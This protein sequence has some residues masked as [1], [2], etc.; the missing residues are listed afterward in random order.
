M[1]HHNNNKIIIGDYQYDPRPIGYGSFSIVYKGYSIR[2]PDQCCAIKKITR[3]VD[4]KSFQNEVDVMRQLNHP[5]ILKLYDVYQE[6]DEF[7]LVLEFCRDGDLS[8]YIDRRQTTHDVLYMR[9]ILE[10]L[11]YLHSKQ[12]LHRDLK[13][14]NVLL[15]HHVI[16]ISDF[17]FSK[18]IASNELI[19][20]YCGSPMYMSPE[21]IKTHQYNLKSDI[22]SLGVILYELFAKRHPYPVGNKKELQMICLH[23]RIRVDMSVFINPMLI[24]YL[25]LL[26]QSDPSRRSEWPEVFRVGKKVCGEKEVATVRP[27][28][29]PIPI[30]IPQSKSASLPNKTHSILPPRAPSHSFTLS[31][32]HKSSSSDHY[33]P[34]PDSSYSSS[35]LGL[36]KSLNPHYLHDLIKSQEDR[37]TTHTKPILGHS[38]TFRPSHSFS[39]LLDKTI[40]SIWK[41]SDK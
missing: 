8:K 24:E 39:S 7:Y 16:K 40:K 10:G 19:S 35:P 23:D 4:T 11:E 26:L 1:A 21:M 2:D 22:W 27:R 41:S 30:P 34:S 32:I 3:L 6:Q 13:P 17:G 25:H 5:N 29:V 14:Q 20:T 18:T 31:A 38:P 33:S 37:D 9:Q 28:S 15:D 36:S 12:I